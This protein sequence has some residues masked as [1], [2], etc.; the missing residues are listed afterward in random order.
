MV[1][2]LLD[3]GYTDLAVLDI[4]AD[5]LAVSQ[6]RLG[7]RAK[8]VEWLVGDVSDYLFD[9]SFDV[10]H[11]RA[12][13]HFLI[14]PESL[15]RYLDTLHRT[16]ALGGHAVIATFG[17]EGPE[18]CSGL[19]VRRYAPTDMAATLGDGFEAVDHVEEHHNTPRGAVQHFVYG[20]YQ[21]LGC[22]SP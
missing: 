22:P 13:L 20:L 21:H 1:D 16:L 8:T 6:R 3:E 19:P 17:P 14:D 7:E 18:T 4:A 9:R 15:S 10:W 2:S 5:S 11:D 12:L